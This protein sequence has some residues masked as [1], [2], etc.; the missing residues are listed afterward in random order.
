[1]VLQNLLKERV[2]I[3]NLRFILE[4]LASYGVKHKKVDDL[5]ERVRIS[6]K[7]QITESLLGSD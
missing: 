6:L 2:S 1:M 3:R 7:R 4:V 5:V